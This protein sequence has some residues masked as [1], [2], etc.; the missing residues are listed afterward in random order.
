MDEPQRVGRD[1]GGLLFACCLTGLLLGMVLS[2]A[3][4]NADARTVPLVIGVPALLV[5]S[6][7]TSREIRAFSRESRWQG[8]R[9][10]AGRVRPLLSTR[11]TPEEPGITEIDDRWPE[12][13]GSPA[14][15][16]T[17][18][19]PN[20]AG[21]LWVAGLVA[22]VGVFGILVAAPMFTAA[23]MRSVGRE[24]WSAVVA[25]SAGT[26]VVLHLLF[27]WLLDVELYRGMVGG[28]M[29]S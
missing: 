1:P 5:A 9:R 4:F 22:S 14:S 11:A 19:V 25:L 21:L 15:V 28:W 16:A 18:G 23:Y 2:A 26:P 17:A 20:A 3:G 24:R 12:A 13:A 7:Q 6:L 27:T 29:P 10:G 8:R